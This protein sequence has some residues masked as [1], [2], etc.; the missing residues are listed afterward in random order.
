MIT[1]SA[2][3]ILSAAAGTNSLRDIKPPV[4]IQSA[5][6][7]VWLALGLLAVVILAVIVWKLLRQRRAQVLFVP[8][9]P[10]HVRARRKLEDA[11]A[12]L[13]QPKPFCTL[14][15][16]TLRFYLEERFDFRA[17]ERTTEE[18]LHEL[19]GTDRLL[20][21]QKGSLGR[22]LERCDLVKFARYEPAEPELRDLHEAAVRLVDETEPLSEGVGVSGQSGQ[23]VGN[24]GASVLASRGGA[25]RET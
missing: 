3:P 20:P 17:P 8:P 12:L 23:S 15:S 18:F 16:D 10:A 24:G 9:I 22:F 21:E 11:L 2:N 4:E 14:V 13:A 6:A 25:G 19:Q 7:W 5:W 1:N